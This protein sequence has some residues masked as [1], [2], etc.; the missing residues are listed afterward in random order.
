MIPENVV[1]W[2]IAGF[3]ATGAFMAWREQYRKVQ[4]RD[5]HEKIRCQL[6]E[7]LLGL[8]DRIAKLQKLDATAIAMFEMTPSEISDDDKRIDEI[9]D[10]INANISLSVAGDFFSNTGLS[11]TRGVTLKL[12]EHIEFLTNRA[13]RLKRIADDLALREGQSLHLSSNKEITT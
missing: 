7:Y 12:D 11:R 1:L 5:A 4:E 2:G 6:Y 10:Y 9:F 3:F 8:E 13:T